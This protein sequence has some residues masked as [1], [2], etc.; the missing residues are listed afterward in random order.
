MWNRI[1]LKEK[2]KAAFRQNYW[3]C[4]VVALIAVVILGTTL[5]VRGGTGETHTYD[6]GFSFRYYSTMT[7]AA[8]LCFT[9]LHIFV[10]NVLSVGCSKFF[11]R[12]AEGRATLDQVLDGFRDS[13]GR[14]VVTMFLMKLYVALWSLL[15]VIPGIVKAYSY[16]LVPYILADSPEMPR[17]EALQLSETLMVGNKMGAFLL[18]LSF[19]GWHIL[20]AM[21][22]GILGV[23]YVNPY[24]EATKA[25]LYRALRYGPTPDL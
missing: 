11:L 14:N 9:V 6:H 1:T 17:R 12:N 10:F 7:G 19:I 13:F 5:T 8:V 22:C 24:I 3:K 15:L 2:G 20:S 21:T 18:D 25:E 16:M 23:F 4:V